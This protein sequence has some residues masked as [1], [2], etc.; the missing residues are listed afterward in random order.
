MTKPKEAVLRGIVTVGISQ[1]DATNNFRLAALGK[2]VQVLTDSV[3]AFV[4]NSSDTNLFNPNTGQIDLIPINNVVSSIDFSSYSSSGGVEAHHHL[5]ASCS[6]HTVYEDPEF[7]KF[8]PV[9]ATSLSS[10]DDFD[11]VQQVS[12]AVAATASVDETEDEGDEDET[13]DLPDPDDDEPLVIASVSHADA[14]QEFIRQRNALG[15]VSLSSGGNL[16]ANYVVCSDSECG[17]HIVSE[18]NMAVASCPTCSAPTCEPQA[19]P[20]TS[21][22][23]EEQTGGKRGDAVIPVT[24]MVE[25]VESTSSDDDTAYYADL[26]IALATAS[27]DGSEPIDATIEVSV[28]STSKVD[29]EKN[30]ADLDIVLLSVSGS[31]R[32]MAFYKGEPVA[33]LSRNDAN[34]ELFDK[35]VYGTVVKQ[36]AS[37]EGIVHTLDVMGFKPFNQTV[38]VSAVA[39]EIAD[40]EILVAKNELKDTKDRYQEHMMACLA[41]A[42]IGITKGFFANTFNPLKAQLMSALATAGVNGAEQLIDAAFASSSDA[43]HR[44]LFDKSVELSALPLEVRNSM[45]QAVASTNYMSLSSG[46][47]ETALAN[48]GTP[49]FVEQTAVTSI[50][51]SSSTESLTARIARAVNSL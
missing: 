50:S 51:T 46:S 38:S 22:V 28:S 26:D 6:S 13:E 8:C 21:T 45:A 24:V 43:Y 15:G 37:T 34:A 3:S 41:T 29:A 32:W 5:C 39:K 10:S 49:T 16:I 31:P 23:I 35:S 2:N 14:V 12:D 9:C 48:F 33:S 40:K 30:V 47:L 19:L 17:C 4:S 11:D 27:S 25:N 36:A 18:S 7:V 1:E 42:S 44:T 20:A